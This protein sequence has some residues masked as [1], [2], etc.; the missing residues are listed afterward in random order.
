MVLAKGRLS[1]LMTHLRYPAVFF[2][3][4]LP[5]FE[6]GRITAQ[7]N[8][9]LTFNKQQG[10]LGMMCDA[11]SIPPQLFQV[12]SYTENVAQLP[13]RDDDP[14]YQYF[15]WVQEERNFTNANDSCKEFSVTVRSTSE[16]RDANACHLQLIPDW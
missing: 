2:Q 9:Y 3:S 4:L 10:H 8:A 14:S 6:V 5:R 12:E 1:L 15:E 11:V 16:P 13:N 7:Y